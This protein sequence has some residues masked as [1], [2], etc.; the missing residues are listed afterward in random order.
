MIFIKMSELIDYHLQRTVDL[1]HLQKRNLGER[2]RPSAKTAALLYKHCHS[3]RAPQ[4]KPEGGRGEEGEGTPL[5][6]RN[7]NLL[8]KCQVGEEVGS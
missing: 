5:L 8:K 4:S 1:E 3:S 7:R 6:H 2:S